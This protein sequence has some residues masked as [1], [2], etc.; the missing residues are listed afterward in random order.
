MVNDHVTCLILMGQLF[1]INS[2]HEPLGMFPWFKKKQGTSWTL[3]GTHGFFLRLTRQDGCNL[4]APV[5]YMTE[6]FGWAAV[7]IGSF[8]GLFGVSISGYP[9]VCYL[10]VCFWR[11]APRYWA[12][13]AWNVSF[14]LLA[15]LSA[16][17]NYTGTWDMCSGQTCCLVALFWGLP[18]ISQAEFIHTHTK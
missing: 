5:E 15:T 13:G 4:L 6:P 16:S 14:P 8:D 10:S 7:E 17:M 11:N 12:L 9:D 3:H 1:I 18:S 2:F